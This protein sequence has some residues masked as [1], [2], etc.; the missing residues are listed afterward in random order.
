MCA[1]LLALSIGAVVACDESVLGPTSLD[2]EFTLAPGETASIED[3][4]IGVRFASVLSDSRC[5]V[6]VDCIHAG[7]AQVRIT[8][9]RGRTARDYELQT[10]GAPVRHDDVT[11]ALVDLLPNRHSARAIDPGA[12]RATFR[13]VR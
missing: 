11:I 5:P 2:S 8:V 4:G 12:Y 6:D 13:V 1:L 3:T 7:N 10:G 9:V